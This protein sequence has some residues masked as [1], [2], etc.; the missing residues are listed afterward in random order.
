MSQFPGIIL[1]AALVNNLIL[2][3]LVGVSAFF[4]YTNSLRNAI[5][6]AWISGAVMFG[7][8]L[9]NLLLA[10]WILLPLNLEILQLILFVSVS[11]TLTSALLVF[12]ESR[13]QSSF[14]RQGLEF[15]LISGNSAI[16]ALSLLNSASIRSI[17]ESIT[18][19]LGAALGFA[20]TLVLFAALRE[21][22]ETA[23]I[24]APFRGAPIQ[25]ISAGIVAM[26]LL[27][28]AGLA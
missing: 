7:S 10:R 19:C 13:L 1:A 24:P 22:L 28:F 15:Y 21:R 6:L 12:L 8:A 25:L 23:T 9:I 17:T 5:E 27:G 18:Y 3:Q 14:R 2:V 26:C 20:L 4:A 16:V 11:A